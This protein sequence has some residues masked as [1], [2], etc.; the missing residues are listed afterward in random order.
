MAPEFFE[1]ESSD[2]LTD[3]EVLNP[4]D[5]D[6]DDIPGMIPGGDSDGID[7]STVNNP[8]SGN[9]SYERN[10]PEWPLTPEEAE[11][12]DRLFGIQHYDKADRGEPASQ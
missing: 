12:L 6:M 7:Q 10:L 9:P 4:E 2:S 5:I 1:D 3:V 11:I 8:Q